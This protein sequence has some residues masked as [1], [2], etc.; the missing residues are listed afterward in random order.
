[1]ENSEVTPIDSKELWNLVR[2]NVFQ[3]SKR[4]ITGHTFNKLLERQKL[5]FRDCVIE[6]LN[7]DQAYIE[8]IFF[9]NCRFK[10]VLEFRNLR[11]NLSLNISNK[12]EQSENQANDRGAD[13]IFSK[14]SVGSILING[15]FFNEILLQGEEGNEVHSISIKQTELTSGLRAS[16]Y[17]SIKNL[18]IEN[19]TVNNV[20][21]TQC[22]LPQF[23][24]FELKCERLSIESGHIKSMNLDSSTFNQVDLD[25]RF[26]NDLKINNTN[27]NGNLLINVAEGSIAGIEING[28]TQDEYL[29]RE[30]RI[31][32]GVPLAKLRIKGMKFELLDVS[33]L[34]S[35]TS[36]SLTNTI[37]FRELNLSGVNIPGLDFDVLKIKSAQFK[38]HRTKFNQNNLKLANV[39][40]STQNRAYELTNLKLGI[41]EHIFE[42]K[43]LKESYREFKVHFL[44]KHNYFDAMLFATN[45]LRVEQRIKHLETWFISFKSFWFNFGDWLVLSTNKWFSNYG[46]SWTRPLIWWL[47]FFHL[48]PF[49]FI[50]CYSNLGIRPAFDFAS[51]TW[52]VI[53]KD[54]TA[55]VIKLYLKLLFPIHGTS[56]DINLNGVEKSQ[57]LWDVLL[58]IPDLFLRIFSSYFIF[59][60]VRGTRKFNF[61]I[62]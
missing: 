48:I 47:F 4:I 60:V 3:I 41:N 61:K 17:S 8:T 35:I 58:G 28:D 5:E 11:F 13:L 23:H 7:F 6:N 12:H 26:L 25:I 59:L 27:I 32:K 56:V 51:F 9:L 45:E 20:V 29:V 31:Q 42:L 55:E 39:E 40:W 33:K 49:C 50:I 46:L 15:A 43:N 34:T 2:S 22:N 57:D 1:M 38:I 54:A 52:Q 14:G 30:L 36:F 10:G 16:N 21:V 19:S 18:A 24:S 53:D 37:V 62:G 44:E